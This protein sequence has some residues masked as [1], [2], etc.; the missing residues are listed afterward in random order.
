MEVKMLILTNQ[1]ILV[2]QIE[3]TSSDL[4]G[5]DCKITEPFVV[6]SDGILSP[7]LI[8][9]TSQNSF[10][11]HSD[12]ILTLIEPKPTILEKYQKLIK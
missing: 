6:S 12:K 10:M 4:G 5:P 1:L 7:W 9:Y 2:A 11:M 3:E 8:D